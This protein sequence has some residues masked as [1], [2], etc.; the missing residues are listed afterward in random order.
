MTVG[1]IGAAAEDDLDTFAPDRAWMESA[2][3][4]MSEAKDTV[5]LR[6]DNGVLT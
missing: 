1:D 6:I 5:T 2:Q 4:V 3:V